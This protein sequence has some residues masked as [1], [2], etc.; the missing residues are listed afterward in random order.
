MPS[1]KPRLH[2]LRPSQTR[3][4]RSR[5]GQ[6]RHLRSTPSRTQAC[7]SQRPN[8]HPHRPRSTRAA[9]RHP[10]SRPRKRSANTAPQATSNSRADAQAQRMP[11]LLR[12]NQARAPNRVG[13]ELRA[14]RPLSDGPALLSAPLRVP[15][16]LSRNRARTPDRP[17][18]ELARKQGRELRSQRL[19]S[20]GAASGAEAERSVGLVLR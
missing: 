8:Q 7:C 4:L 10:Q 17:G 20:H 18:G 6:M 14:Q 12:S 3:D 16:L 9:A 15:E 19:A 2:S 11:E 1:Q 5:L 13:E